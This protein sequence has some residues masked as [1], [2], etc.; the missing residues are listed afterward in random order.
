MPTITRVQSSMVIAGLGLALFACGD[1][2]VRSDLNTEGPPRVITV[3]ATSESLGEAATYC[4]TDPA[5]RLNANYC[6][7]DP[8]AL[9][10]S[11]LTDTLPIGWEVRVVFNELL[12]AA[13]AEDLLPCLDNDHNGRC[14]DTNLNPSCSIPDVDCVD[15]VNHGSLVRTQPV[16][17]NCGGQA[18]PYDGF[19]QP[20]GNHLTQ[21][22]GPALIIQ[23][24]FPAGFAATGATCEV[25]VRAGLRGKDMQEVTMGGPYSFQIAPLGIYFTDPDSGTTNVDPGASIDIQF[26]AYM[27]ANTF[28]NIEVTETVSGTAHPVVAFELFDGYVVVQS[29]N[30]AWDPGIE[31]TLTVNSGVG[32]IRGGQFTGPFSMTFTTTAN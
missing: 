11:T 26:N 27:D 3:T 17:L 5:E 23:P 7:T 31:Y 24:I 13:D 30:G 29:A 6:P 21:T 28:D 22:P 8:E 18:I 15:G 19:Y 12:F 4:S 32:D 20:A 25:T 9:G 16:T 10:V 1:E 14:E 2:D